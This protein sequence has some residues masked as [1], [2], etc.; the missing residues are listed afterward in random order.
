MQNYGNALIGAERYDDA[1]LWLQRSLSLQP[2]YCLA[3]L[4]LG[5]AYKGNGDAQNARLHLEQSLVCNPNLRAA[6][7]LLHE[8]NDSGL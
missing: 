1:I 5:R 7:R 6:R 2:R 8:L 3:M 4:N